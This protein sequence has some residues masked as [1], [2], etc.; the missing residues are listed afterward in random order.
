[1]A[2]SYGKVLR[3]GKFVDVINMGEGVYKIPPRRRSKIKTIYTDGKI[4]ETEGIS[5]EIAGSLCKEETEREET[6]SGYVKHNCPL[7]KQET[8][9]GL[10][11]KECEVSLIIS[12]K[13]IDEALKERGIEETK[14]DL[15]EMLRGI[16]SKIGDVFEEAN[17]LLSETPTKR[18]IAKKI[19]KRPAKSVIKAS[20]NEGKVKVSGWS[21]VR[22]NLLP[23]GEKTSEEKTQK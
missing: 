4:E 12:G 7:C 14:V 10:V 3:D 11:C 9:G 16:T 17:A 22:R 19:A 6:I 8:S 15:D 1:M 18:K 5:N 2:A 13:S 23:D 20:I 21:K